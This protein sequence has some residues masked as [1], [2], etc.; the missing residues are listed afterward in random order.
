LVLVGRRIR[1][2]AHISPVSGS[3]QRGPSEGAGAGR[4]GLHPGGPPGGRQTYNRLFKQ[5]KQLGRFA[6]VGST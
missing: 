5:I 2:R 1:V 3:V 4:G 6:A